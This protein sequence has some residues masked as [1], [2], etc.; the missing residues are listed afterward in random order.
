MAEALLDPRPR[1]KKE[2]FFKNLR[3]SFDPYIQHKKGRGTQHTRALT[4]FHGLQ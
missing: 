2:R 1:K 4:N 3:I